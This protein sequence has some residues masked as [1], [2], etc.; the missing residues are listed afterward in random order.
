MKTI[1]IL[2]SLNYF[3]IAFVYILEQE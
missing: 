3:L 2:A 1:P